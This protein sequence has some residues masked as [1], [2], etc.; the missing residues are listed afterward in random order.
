MASARL[1]M[2]FIGAGSMSAHSFCVSGQPP[3]LACTDTLERLALRAKSDVRAATRIA[4]NTSD[5]NEQLPLRKQLC[6]GKSTH[7]PEL[8]V[9][10]HHDGL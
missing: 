3:E 1:E 5:A 9:P 8:D 4:V 6:R 10:A 7:G 2:A